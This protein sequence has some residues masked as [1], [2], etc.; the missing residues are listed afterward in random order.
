MKPL[1]NILPR[2]VCPPAGCAILPGGQTAGKRPSWR[3]ALQTSLKKQQPA[4]QQMAT[5][6]LQ[7]QQLAVM[8]AAAAAAALG[9]LWA[10]W[11][12]GWQPLPPS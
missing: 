8:A 2:F 10:G 1:W 6:A 12:E 7:P 3:H 9:R 5:A 4:Q 11:W